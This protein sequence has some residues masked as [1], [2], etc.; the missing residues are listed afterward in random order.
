MIMSTA[1]DPLK[2][3]IND[4]SNMF[5]LFYLFSLRCNEMKS[6]IL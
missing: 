3:A 6:F 2:V 5:S 4:V 1:T